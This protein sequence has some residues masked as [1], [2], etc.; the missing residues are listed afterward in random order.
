MKDDLSNNVI[1]KPTKTKYFETKKMNSTGTLPVLIFFH[2]F[3]QVNGLSRKFEIILA[4][5][6]DLIKR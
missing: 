2:D 5:A 4:V 6:V 3:R 1:D